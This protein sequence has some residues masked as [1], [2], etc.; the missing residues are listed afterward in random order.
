MKKIALSIS[1]LSCIYLTHLAAMNVDENKL[2]QLTS[3]IMR[4][5]QNAVLSV[6]Q[7]LAL[8]DSENCLWKKNRNTILKY[9]EVAVTTAECSHDEITKK[10]APVPPPDNAALAIYF[11]SASTLVR[12]KL[13]KECLESHDLYHNK[14]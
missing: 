7:D 9:A 2:K 4:F 11:Q 3:N 13:I 1:L 8:N 10:Y 14:P 12:A 5:D 6:I